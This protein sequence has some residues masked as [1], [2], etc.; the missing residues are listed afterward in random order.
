MI[1]FNAGRKWKAFRTNRRGFISETLLLLDGPEE[2][3][4]PY[5]KT[6]RISGKDDQE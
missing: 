5:A 3:S 6:F 1:Y 2:H 4:G